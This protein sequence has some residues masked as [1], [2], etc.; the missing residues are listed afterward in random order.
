MTRNK[1]KSMENAF[2][3]KLEADL[4]AELRRSETELTQ[5]RVLSEL[6]GITNKA[7]L[8]Q[9]ITN[10]IQSEVLAAFLLIPVLEVVWAD[11]NVQPAE[12]DVVLHAVAEAGIR[13]SSLAFQLTQ[14]W[15]ERRPEP[16]LMKLWTDYTRELMGQLTPDAQECI[17]DTVLGHARAVAEAAGGFL[18]FGCVSDREEEVL[19]ALAATFEIQG[20]SVPPSNSRTGN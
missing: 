5:E 10:G 9:L 17:Q 13:K 2:F 12:R 6:S 18:G 19:C 14:Q 11:G 4:I 15:L 16:E 7:I 20:Q 3:Q 1:G 8:H